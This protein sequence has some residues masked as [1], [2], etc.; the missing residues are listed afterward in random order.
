MPRELPDISG[1]DIDPILVR[2]HEKMQQAKKEKKES[3]DA[4]MWGYTSFDP[5]KPYDLFD[6]RVSRHRDGPA[7]VLAGYAGHVMAD[8]YSGNMSVILAPDSKMTRMACWAHARRHLHEHQNNNME[9]AALPLAIINQLY[10]IERR[11]ANLSDEERGALR[12]RELR[13]LLDR[14][15]TFLDGPEANKLLPSL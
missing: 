12:Q 5:L 14:L 3:L 13:M 1:A 4:K 7:E 15:R 8:C 9:V 10:D 11:G 6:F 2:L